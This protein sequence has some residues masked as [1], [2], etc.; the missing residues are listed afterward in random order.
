MGVNFF[1]RNYQEWGESYLAHQALPLQHGAAKLFAV[2]PKSYFCSLCNSINTFQNYYFK[3]S[4]EREREKKKKATSMSW[5]QGSAYAVCD[6]K[7]FMLNVKAQSYIRANCCCGE[8]GNSS[9]LHCSE[10]IIICI[11]IYNICGVWNVM[12]TNFIFSKSCHWQE[13][14]KAS[15]QFIAKCVWV[16]CSNK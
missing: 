2:L 10:P 1:C 6:W 14:W 13:R 12:V 16:A 7:N 8:G 5:S 4:A 11:I 9:Q 3:L 15:N